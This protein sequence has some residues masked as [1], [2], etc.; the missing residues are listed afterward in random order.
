MAAAIDLNV[1]E[2]LRKVYLF[3]ELNDKHLQRVVELGRVMRHNAGHA[4]A[5]QG[6]L[7]LWFHLL[8]DGDA[9][10][11]VGGTLRRTLVPGDYFGEIAVIDQQLRSASVVAMTP[12]RTWSMS[13]AAFRELLDREPSVA[14]ELLLGLCTRVRELEAM[15]AHEP[16][17]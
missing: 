14:R 6:Q 12:A 15:M 9:N 10:V 16:V 13:G 4:I 17:G 2:Q 7:G 1:V 8:L 3:R 11:I 5:N